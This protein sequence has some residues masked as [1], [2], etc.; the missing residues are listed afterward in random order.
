[1]VEVLAIKLVFVFCI[2][3]SAALAGY[4]PLITP[5]LHKNKDFLSIGNCFAAGIFLIVGVAGLLPDAQ[6]SF[7]EALP[8]SIPL[9]YVLAVFGYLLI[10]FVENVIFD[11]SHHDDHLHTSDNE[12][13]INQDFDIESTPKSSTD[14]NKVVPSI[15]LTSALVVHSIFE[16]I[17]AGLLTSKTKVTTLCLAILIHNMPAAIA[18]GIK[19]QGIKTWIYAALMTAFVFSSPLSIII[20]IFLSGLGYPSV[21]GIFLSIS[22]G[23][24]IYIGCTEIL[25]EEMA[26]TGKKISKFVAFFFGC[27]PIGVGTLFLPE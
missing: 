21:E 1:M 27:V 11:H 19:M 18:L 16:G 17:A 20:G 3:L 4:L 23:T 9:A 2:L 22:A 24:F 26:K 25:P 7:D 13:L 12:S 15:I 8:N 6:D 14:S 5:S 10:F